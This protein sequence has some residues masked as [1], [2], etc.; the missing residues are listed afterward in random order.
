MVDMI[1]GIF[2]GTPS[3]SAPLKN[4]KPTGFSTSGFTTGYTNQ[5]RKQAG[6]ITVTSNPERRGLIN[7]VS[8]L[9]GKQA[10]EIAG[11]RPMVAPGFSA[12]RSSRLK[13]IEDA[14]FR[15]VGDLRENL[16]RRRI[17]GSSFAND[18]LSRADTEFSR[19][20]DQVIA[21]TTLQELEA[22]KQLIGEQYQADRASIE[23][24][25]NN[26]NLEADIAL[27]LA[28]NATSNLTQAALAQAQALTAQREQNLDT[29][30]TLAGGALGAA[31]YT[32]LIK[33]GM[34]G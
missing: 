5:T 19:L 22:T 16:S 10:G 9:F 24:F 8:G 11:L 34:F 26:M 14:R 3:A 25:I 21:E 32:G 33:P 20:N 17:M 28:T 6:G 12:L 23:T 30:G 18:A 29:I 2:G 15:S 31:K 7:Q 1:K 4:L 27:Q 13:Q